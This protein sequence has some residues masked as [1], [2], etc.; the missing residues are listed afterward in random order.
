M[1]WFNIL[2]LDRAKLKQRRKE[3]LE[4][5]EELTQLPEEDR[6]YMRRASASEIAAEEMAHDDARREKRKKTGLSMNYRSPSGT[7][8]KNRPHRMKPED[9]P[10]P[11]R[12]A[13]K[14]EERELRL[15]NKPPIMGNKGS[16]FRGH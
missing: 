4:E 3:E 7:S 12:K 2:K 1:K 5:I 14:E 8:R 11:R 9:R 15:R 6:E 10:K 13:T 16:G